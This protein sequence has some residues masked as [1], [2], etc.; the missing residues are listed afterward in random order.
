MI[1]PVVG[2]RMLQAI[3][4]PWPGP[5]ADAAWQAMCAVYSQCRPARVIEQ[6]RSGYVV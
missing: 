5:P 4:W 2:Y 1:E 3:G 6:H